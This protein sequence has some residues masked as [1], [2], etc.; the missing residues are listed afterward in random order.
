MEFNKMEAVYIGA[1]TWCVVVYKSN[2]TT[3]SVGPFFDLSNAERFIAKIKKNRQR[4]WA[5]RPK[6]GHLHLNYGDDW[7]VERNDV[8]ECRDFVEMY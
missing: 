2:S 1:S 6:E 5:K 4:I 7:H 3:F 8:D